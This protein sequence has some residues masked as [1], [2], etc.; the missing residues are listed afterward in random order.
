MYH[1]Q[2]CMV[3]VLICYSFFHSVRKENHFFFCQLGSVIGGLQINGQKTDHQEK[4]QGLFVYTGAH[5]VASDQRELNLL[6]LLRKVLQRTLRKSTW[7]GNEWGKN[8]EGTE[9]FGRF[10]LCNFSSRYKWS[11]TSQRGDFW[12]LYFQEALLKPAKEIRFLMQLLLIQ[13]CSA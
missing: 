9:C 8:V 7:Q 3:W 11:W 10:C 4:R 12:Q 13:I 1:W 6:I 2:C 5:R